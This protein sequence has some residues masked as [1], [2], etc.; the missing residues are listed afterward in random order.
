[1]K[2]EIFIDKPVKVEVEA[3]TFEQAIKNIK[4]QFNIDELNEIKITL[5]IDIEPI[6]I[7]TRIE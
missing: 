7:N 3:D 2:F 5:P 1:M 6:E 4:T